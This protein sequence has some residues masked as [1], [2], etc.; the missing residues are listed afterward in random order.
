MADRLENVTPQK[1]I[2]TAFSTSQFTPNAIIRRMSARF[3]GRK[4]KEVERF[5]KFFVVG[6]IGFVVDFSTLNILLATILRPS[7]ESDL[8]VILASAIAFTAAVTSNFI[9]N[10]FWTYPD[11]RSRPIAQQVIQFFVVN[12]AGLVFRSVIITLLYGP[13]GQVA[14]G[15]VNATRPETITT[16]E[17]KAQL[18]SNLALALAVLVVMLWN[19]FVNRYWTYNDVD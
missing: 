11:S 2:T 1:P 5:I 13:L 18:G 4:A 12:I 17:A 8:P 7:Q 14:A 3:G 9:W 16:P 19:F 6:G 15:V 10:R